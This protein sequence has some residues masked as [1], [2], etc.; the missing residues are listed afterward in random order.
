M[1]TRPY[2]ALS[3]SSLQDYADCPRRFKLRYLEGLNY[4][5]VESEPALENEKGL[6]EGEIFHRLVQKSLLG[7]DA[8]R[9]GRLARSDNLKRWW[10]NW[11]E[12]KPKLDGYTIYPE[13]SLTSPLGALRLVAKYDLIA[14]LDGQA[15]IYDWKTSRKRPSNE[16]LAARWQTRVYLALLAQSGGTLN[17][18]KPILPDQIRMTY[19]FADFPNEPATFNYTAAQFKRDWD[20]LLKL[21]EEIPSAS[22]YPMTDDLQKC[23]YCVFRSYCDRGRAAGEGLDSEIESEAGKPFDVDFEQIGEIAF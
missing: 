20:V 9:L 13:F 12:S 18:S 15:L 19:W 4:P 23:S 6:E 2:P 21:S 11:M 16:K 10:Q 22:D 1:P 14:L 3:Q 5:A 8:A 17:G 7:M